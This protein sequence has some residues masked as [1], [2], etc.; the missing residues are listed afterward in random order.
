MKRVISR[1]SA[2][3]VVVGF[4]HRTRTQQRFAAAAEIEEI[5]VTAQKRESKLQET[6][7]AI[8]A[9]TQEQIR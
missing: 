8:T 5:V 4:V 6:P 2:G 1:V 7:I 3:L 9:I